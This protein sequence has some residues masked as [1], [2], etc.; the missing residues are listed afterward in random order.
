MW[1]REG[2]MPDGREGLSWMRVLT[3]SMGVRMAWVKE[4]QKAPATA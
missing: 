4:Q 1:V 3:T 2:K